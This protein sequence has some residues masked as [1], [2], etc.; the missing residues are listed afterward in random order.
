M[1]TLFFTLALLL[2]CNFGNSQVV[3]YKSDSYTKDL[4]K[5]VASVDF[6]GVDFTKAKTIGTDESVEQFVKAFT[7]INQL[8]ITESSKYNVEK[9]FNKAFCNL[10]AVRLAK[11]Y[12]NFVEASDLIPENFNYYLSMDDIKNQVKTYDTT[13]SRSDV[14]LVLIAEQLNKK[15]GYASYY[16]TFFDTKT[17]D[18]LAVYPVKGDVGGFGLRNFWARSVYESFDQAKKI[19]KK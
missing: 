3:K 2:V 18:I 4:Y 14:G 19:M 9:Y 1:K 8:F 15:K 7:A 16:I 13:A 5:D 12:T 11:V 6:Y 10:M 17:K